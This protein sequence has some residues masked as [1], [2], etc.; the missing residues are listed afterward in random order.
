LLA[1]SSETARVR[2]EAMEEAKRRSTIG[3]D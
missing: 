2:R 1:T 3:T